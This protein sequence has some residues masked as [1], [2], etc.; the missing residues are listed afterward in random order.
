VVEEDV[1]RVSRSTRLII[2]AFAL[3]FLILVLFP[4]IYAAVRDGLAYL[5]SDAA[6][7]VIFVL[8]ALATIG[9]VTLPPLLKAIWGSGEHNAETGPTGPITRPEVDAVRADARN[10]ARRLQTFTADR[11]VG[12]PYRRCPG[13]ELPS[14][15]TPE[16]EKLDLE[17]DA[18][19]RET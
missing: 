4:G 1:R 7:R 11:R 2:I 16:R 5:F 17:E 13:V 15:G 18:Y 6:A 3:L 10:V 8:A 19:D 9:A 12:S 14:E